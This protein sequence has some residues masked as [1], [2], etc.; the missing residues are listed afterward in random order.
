[1]VDSHGFAS[2]VDWIVIWRKSSSV[3]FRYCS[4]SLLKEKICA[5]ISSAFADLRASLATG[6]YMVHGVCSRVWS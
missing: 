4:L 2:C 5:R 1:M 6:V 3:S